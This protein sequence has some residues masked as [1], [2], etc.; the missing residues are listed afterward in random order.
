MSDDASIFCSA[1]SRRGLL[2]GAALAAGATMV[3]DTADAAAA[4]SDARPSPRCRSRPARMSWIPAAA[5]YTW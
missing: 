3:P 4:P 1:L 2:S 5:R